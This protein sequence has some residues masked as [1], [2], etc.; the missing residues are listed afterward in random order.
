[1]DLPLCE[2]EEQTKVRLDTISQVVA[3]E[4]GEL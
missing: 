2:G 4:N 1:M 3:M